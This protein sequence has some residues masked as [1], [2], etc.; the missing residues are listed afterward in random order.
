VITGAQAQRQLAQMRARAIGRY[1]LTRAKGRV[2]ELVDPNTSNRPG[3]EV[4]V[5]LQYGC[6]QIRLR[7]M[8]GRQWIEVFDFP[9]GH[10]WERRFDQ[11]L[12]G[13]FGKPA[14]AGK[15][16]VAGVSR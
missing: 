3:Y 13:H 1:K 10:P 2:E 12:D 8:L 6:R 11:L 7:L 14:V 4:G 16:T 15:K 9:I 5:S